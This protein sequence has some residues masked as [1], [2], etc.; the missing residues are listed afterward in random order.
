[1][2]GSIAVN[3]GVFNALPA[4]IQDQIR[5]AI[6]YTQ[7]V[8]AEGRKK[9]NSAKLQEMRDKSDIITMELE[10]VSRDE[11]APV[12]EPAVDYYAS[13]IRWRAQT[14]F[15]EDLKVAVAES[16]GRLD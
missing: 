13:R 1:M 14:G 7:S 9:I 4:E 16:E 2:S 11:L 10:D 15:V 8:F 12:P 3:S 6:D 5:E